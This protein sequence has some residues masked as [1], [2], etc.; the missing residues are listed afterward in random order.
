MSKHKLSCIKIILLFYNLIMSEIRIIKGNIF[1]SQMQTIVNTVNC[2]GFMGAGLALEF[3][4]RF[5]DLNEE[6]KQ[7][8][9]NNK[10]KIGELFIYKKSIPWIINFPT[11]IHYRDPSMMSYIEQG[12]DKFSKIYKYERITS[13]AFPQLGSSLGGL[14]WDDVLNLMFTYLEKL[15]DIEIEIYEFDPSAPD[16]LFDDLYE[17]I[18][19]F[20]TRDYKKYLNINQK[21]ANQ[22][23]S[24]LGKNIRSMR[25]FEFVKGIGPT[26]LSKLYKVE[27]LK[28]IQTSFD[29]PEIYE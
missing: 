8:C 22:I 29:I 15:K 25:D 20:D 1:D 18:K 28:N 16:K 27:D 23:K 17:I 13:V 7:M 14:N 4:R 6:Y 10:V 21:V 24:S 2:V 11:K 3:S 9:L 26:S 5:P 19:E 12:L